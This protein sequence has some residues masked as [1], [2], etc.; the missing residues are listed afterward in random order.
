[1]LSLKDFKKNAIAIDGLKSLA[2]GASRDPNDTPGGKTAF[3]ETNPS[4]CDI[5][6]GDGTADHL[7]DSGRWITFDHD[8]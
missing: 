2:G 6:N 8:C 4:T 1:M 5:C 3:G 7:F